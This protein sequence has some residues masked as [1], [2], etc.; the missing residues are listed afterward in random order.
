M[1]QQRLNEFETESQQVPAEEQVTTFIRTFQSQ[2]AQCGVIIRGTARTSVRTNENFVEHTQRIPVMG[3]ESALVNFLFQLGDSSSAVP[4]RVKELNLRPMP[5][6]RFKLDGE[7]T[8]VASFQRRLNLRAP[9]PAAAPTNAPGARTSAI[10]SPTN[11]P[12]PTAKRS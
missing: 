6:Q 4:I 12:P 8:L 3:D 9:V 1:F 5:P 10:P 7:V 11:R 2:A